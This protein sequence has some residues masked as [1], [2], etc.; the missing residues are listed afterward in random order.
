MRKDHVVS[1]RLWD[2]SVCEATVLSISR[3]DD[4]ALLQ[5]VRP[6]QAEFVAVELGDSAALQV[7][8]GVLAI[9]NPLG[10]ANT[11]TAGIVTAKAQGIRVKG[12]WAKLEN[13]IET[14]A[15]IN[16]G[17]SGG[18]LLD[19][20]GRLVGINS[21]GSH[22]FSSHGYAIPVNHVRTQILDL[23]LSPEKLRCA[24]FGMR[25]GTESG[26]VLV[27]EID[28]RGP[29]ARAGLQV[30]DHIVRF[31][32]TA[33]TWSVGF[34]RRLLA[35]STERA[36]ELDIERAGKPIVVT[37]QPLTAP[38]WAVL[39]QT[40][41][42]AEQVPFEREPELVRAASL[43]LHRKFSGDARSEPISLLPSVVR[44]LRTVSE[45]LR[46]GD[47]LLGVEFRQEGTT[48]EASTLRRFTTLEAVQACFDDPATGSY[49]GKRYPCWVFR[50]GA[51]E[52]VSLRA[53]RL[54][55]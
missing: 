24:N 20:G 10:F 30:G 45:D 9:G 25:I 50:A 18:A 51:V 13:L 15:A 35:T 31:D 49:E 55:Q 1:V 17:N 26:R 4:L 43:A 39:L 7:G 38:A 40:G 14:D 36:C 21:A 27:R 52:V 47:L 23:L 3:E 8:E 6:E 28:P 46:P 48:A 11:I 12:R 2:G 44:V 34:A 5:L 42:E 37:V 53:K 22:G 41:I 54:M 16:G 19:L 32:K 33:I 29:A